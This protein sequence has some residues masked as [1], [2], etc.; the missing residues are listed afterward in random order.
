MRCRTSLD[1][2]L[3]ADE[4][5]DGR[6][7]KAVAAYWAARPSSDASHVRRLQGKADRR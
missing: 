5:E 6:E 1:S 2:L 7:Y 3:E 4:P